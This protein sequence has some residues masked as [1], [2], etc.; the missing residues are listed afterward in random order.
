M[1]INKIK[2]T[3]LAYSTMI[4]RVQW[5]QNRSNVTREYVIADLIGWTDNSFAIGN[6]L[7]Q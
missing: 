4:T 1:R 7:N 6:S 3:Y 2:V 5:T